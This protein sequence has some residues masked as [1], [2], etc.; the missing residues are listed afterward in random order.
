MRQRKLSIASDF[1]AA[2]FG[3]AALFFLCGGLRAEDDNVLFFIIFV[4]K[5]IVIPFRINF[6]LRSNTI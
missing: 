1:F 3:A 5:Y 2:L 6:T 4:F